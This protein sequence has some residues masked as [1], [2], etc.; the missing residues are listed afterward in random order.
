[1]SRGVRS[2]RAGVRRDARFCTNV[3][4]VQVLLVHYPAAVALVILAQTARKGVARR[5]WLSPGNDPMNT[6]R[7]KGPG[8]IFE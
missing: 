3:L 8:G 7:D 1:M 5:R 2:R 4:F 6:G